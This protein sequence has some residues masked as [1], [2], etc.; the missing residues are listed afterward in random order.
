[1]IDIAGRR[2]SIYRDQKKIWFRYNDSIESGKGHGPRVPKATLLGCHRETQVLATKQ[3]RRVE[4]RRLAVD[5]AGS[6][7]KGSAA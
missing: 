3:M 6:G 2:S 4:R 1:M 7:G 5:T